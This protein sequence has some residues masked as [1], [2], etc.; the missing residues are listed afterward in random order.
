[1]SSSLT[2]L[3]PEISETHLLGIRD[4][5]KDRVRSDNRAYLQAL[6]PLALHVLDAASGAPAAFPDT[7]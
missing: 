7:A 3:I 4:Q 5:S 2:R 6:Q 1:M